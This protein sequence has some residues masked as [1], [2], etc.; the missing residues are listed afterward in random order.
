VSALKF[1]ISQ[2]VATVAIPGYASIAEVDENVKAAENLQPATPGY[3]QEMATHLTTELNS[4]C[5]GCSYCDSCPV[6][7][8]IPKLLESYNNSILSKGNMN[9][10]KSRLKNHWDVDGKLAAACIE[11]GQCETLCTQKLPIIK[12]LAEIAAAY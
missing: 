9:L 1:I 4:L 6:D 10:V 7:I 8:P 12:R 5:T 3:L 2:E 11:C